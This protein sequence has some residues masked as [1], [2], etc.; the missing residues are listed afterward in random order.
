MEG[1]RYRGYL[2]VLAFAPLLS[3]IVAVSLFL[4]SRPFAATVPPERLAEIQSERP[5]S[6]ILPFNLR[7][8]A[9]FKI[10]RLELEQP[11]IIWFST[12]R[13]GSAQAEMFTPYR[14]YNM[15]FTGWTTDQLAEVFERATRIAHPRVAILSLDYFLFSDRW[16]GQLRTSRQMIYGDPLGYFRSSLGSFVRTAMTHWPVFQEYARSPS[17]LIG[18]QTILMHEGFRTDG[19]WLFTEAHVESATKQFR[20]VD[21]LLNSL[22]GAP[23]MSQR[24]KAPIE[25]LANIA[26]E[27]GIKLVAVQLPYIRAGVEFLD[28]S[29]VND[30]FYGIWH[31]FEG[32]ATR[33][34]LTSLGIDF[35]DLAHSPIDNDLENF[36]DAY[37]PSEL[38]M[39]R[40]VR[41]LMQRSDFLAKLAP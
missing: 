16:E 32:S 26:R 38:G 33:L 4:F 24:Q 21:F 11:E 10:R 9:A 19:S 3:V 29:S 31:D 27:R 23:E 5:G 12:S 36:I 14:F 8:N 6:I 13:A 22:S 34:W 1:S 41:E 25:R 18:P 30:P 7:Y 28:R 17:N 2:A 39:Q 40:V 35:I 15:S 37:H 20:N